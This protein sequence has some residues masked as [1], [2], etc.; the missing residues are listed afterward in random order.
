MG[1]TAHLRAWAAQGR[2][3]VPVV[4]DVQEDERLAPIKEQVYKDPRPAEHFDRFHQ[5]VAHARAGLRLRGRADRTTLFS[6]IALPR[7]RHRRRERARTGPVILAPTT[8]R[9]W[10]TS[11][12][13]SRS[14]ARS[15]SWRSRS[16]SSRRWS[17]STR[18][19][20][21][22]RCA[23]A[24]RDEEAFITARRRS[25]TAAGASPCTPRPGARARASCRRRARPGIGR[26]ALESGAPIV[27]VAIYGSSGAQLEAPAVPQGDAC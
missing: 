16:S 24:H 13:A 25:S 22:S 9:S 2:A 6:W 1:R 27:P 23:A 4:S 15:A 5:R 21:S 11:S 26:L 18:T 7:A 8:P 19:A 3:S 14:A 12:S 17:G 20:A 10:T